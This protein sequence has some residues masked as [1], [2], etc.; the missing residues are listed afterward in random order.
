MDDAWGR[1]KAWVELK[2]G[3]HGEGSPVIGYAHRLQPAGNNRIR[4]RPPIRDGI[5]VS[6]DVDDV[7]PV[8]V[9]W[10]ELEAG[11]NAAY[12]ANCHFYLPNYLPR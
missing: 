11:D 4:L 5:D 3:Y 8:A 9:H 7:K 6:R 2:A 10:V 12:V 1:T